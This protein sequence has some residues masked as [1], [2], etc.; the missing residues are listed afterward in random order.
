M[1]IMLV[2]LL[3]TVL[4]TSYPSA[5]NEDLKESIA[6][7]KHIYANNCI[8]C[9]MADGTG[10]PGTFPPLAKSDYLTKSTNSAI[11]AVKYGLEGSIMVNGE[12]YDSMMPQPGLD[13]KQVA[14]VMN[15]ILNSWGNSHGKMIT[16]KHVEEIKRDE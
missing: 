9:H 8:S 6:R 5:Q 15:Y 10:V 4:Y 1:K 3:G 16:Q 2:V 11:E 14:D 7:G 13:D 12:E